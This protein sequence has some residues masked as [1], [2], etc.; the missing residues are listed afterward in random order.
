VNSFAGGPRTPRPPPYPRGLPTRELPCRRA[1]DPHT[2]CTHTWGQRQTRGV[3][4][5]QTPPQVH[6]VVGWVGAQ[7][8]KVIREIE[9]FVVCATCS[10]QPCPPMNGAKGC[11]QP[12]GVGMSA[13]ADGIY[14]QTN[15]QQTHATQKGGLCAMWLGKTW[16][17]LRLAGPLVPFREMC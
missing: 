17:L 4:D 3:A 16:R 2:H 8:P 15:T 5:P 9:H 7:K 11:M 14:L 6:N 12:S 10:P 1:A 13:S